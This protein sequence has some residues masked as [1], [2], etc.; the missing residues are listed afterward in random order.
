MATYYILEN[1]NSPHEEGIETLILALKNKGYKVVLLLNRV[2]YDRIKALQIQNLSNDVITFNNLTVFFTFIK[3]VDK[4][5]VV[6]YNTI[7]VRNSV[8]ILL[9][10]IFVKRNVYCVRNA[11]SWLFFSNHAAKLRSKFFR[12]VSTLIKKILLRKAYFLIVESD[13][14]QRYLSQF[15]NKR[16][17]TV[18]YKYFKPADSSKASL[19][20]IIDLVVPGE[21]DLKRKKLQTL[22][23]AL[24][25]LNTEDLSRIRVTFLGRARE[26]INL[27]EQWK[28]EFGNS[29]IFFREFVSSEVFE[30]HLRSATYIVSSLEIN[31]ESKYL[32]E[33]YGL[34]KGS[35]VFGQ[36]ISYGKPLIINAGFEVP[37]EIETSVI[38]FRDSSDLFKIFKDIVYDDNF[39]YRMSQTSIENS[40]NFSIDCISNKVNLS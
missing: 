37:S 10:S 32:K 26:N 29:F 22:I 15:T 30:R 24:R 31:H 13:K 8:T 16:I 36:A 12:F 3:N 6:I 40:S 9:L 39:N 5:D 2:A 17:E 14:I 27:C 21:V 7:S 11:N 23:D 38:Y 33:V 19:S 18:P 35:G 28:D 4:S 25:M 20:K 1:S 34:S